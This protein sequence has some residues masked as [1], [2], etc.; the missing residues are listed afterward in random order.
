MKKSLTLLLII[1]FAITVFADDRA[2]QITVKKNDGS[3]MPMYSDSYALVIGVSDYVSGWP[4]LPGVMED[5]KAVEAALKDSGF[6]VS[7]SINPDKMGLQ[8]AL[9]NF[10]SAHGLKAENRLLI[11]YA[12]HGHTLKTAYGGKNGYIVPVDAPS[13]YV[14]KSGFIS[15]AINMKQIE[16]YAK[17][18]ESKHVLFLFDSCFAGNIF[19]STRAIPEVIKE[20]TGKPVRQ[21]ITSGTEN[22][23]VPDRSIFRREFVAAI[24]GAADMN[25]DGYVTGTELGQ[26]L[27][28]KVTNYSNR[29]QTP[30]YG[31]LADPN[32][33]KGD[34]VFVVDGKNENADSHVLS[35]KKPMPVEGDRDLQYFNTV[36]DSYNIR[37][38]QSYLDTFPG[39]K[40]REL[41][42]IKINELQVETDRK[43]AEEANK[44]YTPNTE[45]YSINVTDK[46]IVT[47]AGK[48]SLIT[49][50][51]RTI[52]RKGNRRIPFKANIYITYT[53]SDVID[54][55]NRHKNTVHEKAKSYLNR[56]IRYTMKNGKGT[57]S[58]I[59][60]DFR[61]ELN[62]FI[63][64]GRI[65][66]L[67]FVNIAMIKRNNSKTN[68]PWKN[69]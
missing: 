5:V 50:T 19:N 52:V 60:E 44:G 47:K 14:D 24:K 42:K 34:F 59:E 15:K 9:E 65:T 18:I 3:F 64:G 39:G 45:D 11:Y 25:N 63:N 36:K 41:I 46:K 68:P 67:K 20:K 37:M 2:L 1:L 21:F 40:F 33:D 23:K 54:E 55:L 32:L 48:D 17:N 31:K 49:G 10:I 4:D 7:V 61:K 22:Q 57:G 38:L 43:L 26:Y 30:R 62:S 6:N 28:E 35:N 51:V 69:K 8:N 58:F 29:T 16:V 13:P 53:D 12:G 56:K 27:E 66:K